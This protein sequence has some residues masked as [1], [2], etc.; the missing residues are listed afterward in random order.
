MKLCL[1]LPS[2]YQDNRTAKEEEPEPPKRRSL[3]T[4]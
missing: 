2:G 3:L 4:L 1:M